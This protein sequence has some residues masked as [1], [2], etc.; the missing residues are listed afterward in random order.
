MA[1]IKVP[2]LK[3]RS[4]R[5]RW[6]PGPGLRAKGHAGRDLK[7]D[8]GQ[9]LSL[10]A[11]I[12]AAAEINA[13]VTKSSLGS[14]KHLHK[15]TERRS[16]HSCQC[17][18]ERFWAS[19]DFCRLATKTKVDYQDKARV[20]LDAGFAGRHVRA[21]TKPIMYGFW[22]E[23]YAT[24]GHS[25]ANGVLAVVRRVFS[26]GELIGWLPGNS[27]PALRLGRPLVEARVVVWTPAE[28]AC[29]VELADATGVPSVGDAVVI[30]LHTGQRQG[31]VLR[32]E[33]TGADSGRARF[34]VRKTGTRVAVPFTPQLEARLAACCLI[35]LGKN[36]TAIA[37]ARY[38]APFARLQP[39]NSPASSTSGLP[40]SA[41]RRS[42]VW[43]S[44]GAQCQKFAQLP[45]IVSPPFTAR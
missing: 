26:Y 43:R 1:T 22:E 6:E 38:S 37:L 15:Q 41:T 40:T 45:A 7:D 9:W 35:A 24:R 20:F 21:V 10:E 5:P 2:Y 13:N 8:S 12:A 31:D 11:A 39:R 18:F 29:L 25:M 34:H 32:L 44:P 4:G 33:L 36:T 16:T 42:R 28:I 3:W 19:A 27:N 17:L 14:E 30:A 23:V